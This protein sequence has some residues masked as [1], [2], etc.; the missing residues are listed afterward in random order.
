MAKT[1]PPYTAE[2]R[3]QTVELVRVLGGVRRRPRRQ[4][5]TTADREDRQKSRLSTD[6]WTWH[7]VE[8]IHNALQQRG[9]SG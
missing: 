2:F 4:P 9:T 6:V 3:R 1:R 8:V 5:L 7:I